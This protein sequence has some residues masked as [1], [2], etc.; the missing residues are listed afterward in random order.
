MCHFI[1]AVLPKAANV[2]LAREVAELHHRRLV[3]QE[4]SSVAAQL[5][6]GEL[7]F[8]TTPG[9]C[10][11]GTMLG[12]MQRLGV[13]ASRDKDA[14]SARLKRRGWSDAKVAR[15]L[16]DK[17]KAVERN[18]ANRADF[19]QNHLNDNDHW[20]ELLR[21]VLTAQA[22]PYI[23]L[24][25]HWYSGPLT[26]RIRLAAREVVDKPDSWPQALANMREDVV[27]LFCLPGRS[28]T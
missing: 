13:P 24:L 22:T 20:V 18:V 23:G 27:Y 5:G 4:N 8:L 17:D 16:A 12:C 25:L 6:P 3:E 15:W 21:A 1:T 19:C 11:C 7:Y 26:G 28:R 2:A 9:Q 10:D 14:E